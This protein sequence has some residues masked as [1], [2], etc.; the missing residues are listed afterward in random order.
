[1]KYTTLTLCTAFVLVMTG[2]TAMNKEECSM[3]NWHAIGQKDGEEGKSTSNLATYNKQCAE[4]GVAPD[5]DKYSAGHQVGLVSFCTKENGFS[6]GKKGKKHQGIC[7]TDLAKTFESG[8]VIGKEY[9][10]VLSVKN[11]YETQISSKNK[12]IKKL[13]KQ[14]KKIT[15]KLADSDTSSEDKKQLRIDRLGKG[16]EANQLAIEVQKIRPKLAVEEYKYDE[17]VKKYGYL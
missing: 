8:Y 17:L 4:F 12:K 3:A 11:S 1:M 15:A 13:V 14:V 10:A 9:Y 2:C 7:P 5:K 16:Y 6:Q